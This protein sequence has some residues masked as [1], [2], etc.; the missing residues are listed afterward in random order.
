MSPLTDIRLD[1]CLKGP[2]RDIVAK[3]T[4]NGLVLFFQG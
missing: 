2:D 4:A 1:R 3:V